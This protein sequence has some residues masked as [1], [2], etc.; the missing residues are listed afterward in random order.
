GNGRGIRE[1]PAR[2]DG[3]ED[4]LHADVWSRE[5]LHLLEAE[6]GRLV[7]RMGEDELTESLRVRLCYESRD[8]LEGD[9]PG[10]EGGAA[11]AHERHHLSRFGDEA[12][13]CEDVEPLPCSSHTSAPAIGHPPDTEGPSVS[14]RPLG[15]TPCQKPLHLHS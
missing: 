14:R 13:I 12:V 15:V 7:V 11:L 8:L 3:A 2:C 6:P 4:E 5:D 9:V 1:G 10:G